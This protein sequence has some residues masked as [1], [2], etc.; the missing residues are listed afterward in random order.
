[1]S[2]YN[3][4]KYAGKA[5]AVL[6]VTEGVIDMTGS[7]EQPEVET[8]EES[9]PQTVFEEIE[10]EGKHL[11]ERVK[12]LLHEGNI[13]TLR[14]KDKKGKYLLEIPLS[15]GVVAGGVFALAA[16]WAVALSALAGFVADVKIEIARETGTGGE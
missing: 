4:L 14:I 13:R 6:K 9:R 2:V 10:V 16:P 15:V 1:M 8:A 3:A 5:L 7:D 12:E 11:V